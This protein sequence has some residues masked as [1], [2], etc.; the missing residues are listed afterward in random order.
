M[1]AKR[2][3]GGQEQFYRRSYRLQGLDP[4]SPLPKMEIESHM[5]PYPED[6]I[7]SGNMSSF[8]GGFTPR[9]AL[10]KP[11]KALRMTRQQR[12]ERYGPTLRDAYLAEPVGKSS[13]YLARMA[14]SFFG[15]G[16]YKRKRA[17]GRGRYTF[18]SFIRDVESVG[19][20]AEGTANR[21]LTRG[22]PRVL[23]AA[24]S[25][26][27]GGSGLYSGRGMYNQNVLI[28]GGD[29]PMSI[30]MG[31]TD[32]QEVVI[33][34]CEY[35]QDVYGPASAAFSNNSLDLNPGLLE[36]F[37][38]LGQ[39]AANYE[40][41][42]FL[43]LMF[44][45]KS[46]VDASISSTGTTGTLIMATNYNADAAPFLSKESMMQYHGAN[47]TRLDKEMDH[48]VE[49]DPAK[50]AG[51][52]IRYVRTVPL[53]DSQ[54]KKEFDLGKFQWAIVNIPSQFQNQQVGELW[55]S[56]TVKLGKPKLAVSLGRTIAEDRFISNG[57]E[58]ST[59]LLGTQLLKLTQSNINTV[60]SESVS[61]TAVTL[62]CTFPN[63]LTG[64]YEIQVRHVGSK[65]NPSAPTVGGNVSLVSD[66]WAISSY[67]SYWFSSG[68]A[69]VMIV[70]VDVSPA[71]AGVDNTLSIEFDGIVAGA[72]NIEVI[73]YNP[74]LV[75]K[76]KSVADDSDVV[77]S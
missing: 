11:P 59:S 19:R 24:R 74:D 44:H 43:Q 73:Q 75:L 17:T 40:E 8:G 42:E 56:Y 38:F 61:G 39:I 12:L 66:M 52:A 13:Q 36:N 5:I 21:F 18:G 10:V 27:L 33:N 26:G 72:T 57:G 1:Q 49:C 23:G 62:T 53:V 31:A 50:N 46:T 9:Q 2:T 22:L 35:L 4:E 41:Y 45:Y 28:E 29:A 37:P 65:T 55:V 63:F 64:R 16:K 30:G 77:P 6:V 69:P 76:W 70:H 58:T 15:K 54:Q 71:T 47:N 67:L 51:T 14:D 25:V 32:N 7:N 60:W 68:T 48:G 20:R 34:H 3:I